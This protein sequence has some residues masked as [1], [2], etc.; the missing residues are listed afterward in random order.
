MRHAHL[1]IR[2]S[3]RDHTGQH[4][5]HATELIRVNLGRGHSLSRGLALRDGN[6]NLRGKPVSRLREMV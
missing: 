5:V 2:H 1:V 4:D 3:H 6:E